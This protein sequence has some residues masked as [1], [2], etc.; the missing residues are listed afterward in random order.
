MALAAGP[1][2]PKLVKFK[3][4]EPLEGETLFQIR[5]SS[6]PSDCMFQLSLFSPAPCLNEP[7]E[8]DP[9]AV[10]SIS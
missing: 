5:K 10:I 8:N 6:L 4:I 7:S 9:W 3:V 2:P 1:C